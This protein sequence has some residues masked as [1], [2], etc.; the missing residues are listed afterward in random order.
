MELVPSKHTLERLRHLIYVGRRSV[1]G[2]D[3]GTSK[4]GVALCDS[5][6][7]RIRPLRVLSRN[8]FHQPNRNH[9]QGNNIAMASKQIIQECEKHTPCAIVIGLPVAMDGSY[10]GSC[11]Q[12]VDFVNAFKL[13][14]ERILPPAIFWD[15]RCTTYHA[16]VRMHSLQMDLKSRDKIEDG[17]AAGEI[18]DSFVKS[19]KDLDSTSDSLARMYNLYKLSCMGLGS[20]KQSP[21]VGAPPV[22]KPG[23]IL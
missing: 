2:L 6:D 3:I 13:G 20:G 11:R 17:F 10:T 9:R 21:D 18:L 8:V 14:N 7:R 15:E 4:I 1:I 16:R 12:V 5:A 23:H 19:I 22:L